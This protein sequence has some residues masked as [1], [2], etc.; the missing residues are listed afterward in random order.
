[1]ASDGPL[2]KC[3]KSLERAEQ[4]LLVVFDLLGRQQLTHLVLAGRIAD[5]GRAAAHHDDRLV[6][7]LLQP[8]QRHDLHQ[9]ADVEARRRAIESDIGGDAFLLDQRVEAFEVRALMQLAARRDEAEKFGTQP[10]S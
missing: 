5:L 9:V 6:P 2:P 3:R 4:A 8:A 1:M 7:G 10:G